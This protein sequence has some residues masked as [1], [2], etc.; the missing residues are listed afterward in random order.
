M[1]VKAAVLVI[2]LVSLFL[3]FSSIFFLGY[4]ELRYWP[5][6]FSMACHIVKQDAKYQKSKMVLAPS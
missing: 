3:D 5:H 4:W 2:N 6:F 1:G